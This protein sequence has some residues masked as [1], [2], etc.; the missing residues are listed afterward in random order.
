MSDVDL[1]RID[2]SIDELISTSARVEKLAGGFTFTEGPIWFRES[3]LLF[4]DIPVNVIYKWSP[5]DGVSVYRVRSGYDG[6]DTPPG[7]LIGSNGLTMDSQGRLV[8]CEHG[9]RRVT[10]LEQ[11]GSSTVIASHYQGKRLNSPNDAVHK[12][13]GA[14]YFT[15]P[16]YG[17]LLRDQDPAKELAF[18]GVYR[19]LH[20][21]LQLLCTDLTRPNGLVFS[22]DERCLYV[23]NSDHERKTWTQFEVKPDGSLGSSEIFYDATH[24]KEAGVPDGMKADQKGNLYCTGPGGIW[25]FSPQGR[26]LGTLRLPEIPAN[27]HWGDA[28]GKSLYITARTSLYRIRLQIAGIRP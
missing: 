13:D 25:V 2:A 21:E 3:F 19:I 17:L 14:L 24:V 1:I 16:P 20:G 5:A 6:T 27:C 18:N 15:D 9:N 11:D 28:D 7:A 26:H 23:A 8:V 12:S 4:S 10:R 22:P